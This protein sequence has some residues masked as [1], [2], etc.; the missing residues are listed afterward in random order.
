MFNMVNAGVYIR[1]NT[2]AADTTDNRGDGS[3]TYGAK[4]LRCSF[5]NV[6]QEGSLI[7]TC[8]SK[9]DVYTDDEWQ[10]CVRHCYYS[11]YRWDKFTTGE[12]RRMTHLSGCGTVIESCLKNLR[13]MA[14]IQ[15]PRT[16]WRLILT[17]CA[18]VT[19][20]DMFTLPGAPVQ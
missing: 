4:V 3:R 20:S 14:P 7:H 1:G 13:C 2:Y 16:T 6:V 18:G 11:S 17:G 9:N 5:T 15:C 8:A 19:L 10:S 12:C